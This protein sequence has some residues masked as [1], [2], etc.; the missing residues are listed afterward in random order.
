MNLLERLRLRIKLALV[1]ALAS[2]ALIATIAITSSVMRSRMMIDRVGELRA[3]SLNALG[4][5][6]SLE[7]QVASHQ[8]TREQALEQFRR[9]AHAIRFDNGAVTL[10]PRHGTI[11]SSSTAPIL[12][13]RANRQ[14][15]SS[16]TDA[17]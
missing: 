2:L 14:P 3:V 9:A 6:Q 11:S 13:S 17:A 5:A 12:P 16:R 4:L 10:S 7:D 1:M 8:L 15:P